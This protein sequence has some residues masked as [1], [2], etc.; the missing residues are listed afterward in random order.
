[1]T[2]SV[3]KSLIRQARGIV[4]GPD[5]VEESSPGRMVIAVEPNHN[6]GL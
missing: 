2:L 1:M 3:E 5:P 6:Y 4:I